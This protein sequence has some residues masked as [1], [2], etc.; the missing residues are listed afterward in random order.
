VTAA[1]GGAGLLALLVA[2]RERRL[3]GGRVEWS[4]DASWHPDE[5]G[6]MRAHDRATGKALAW[7]PL[8]GSQQAFLRC[9]VP[10]VLFEGSRGGGK[11]L[12]LLMDFGQH[13]GR[14]Y[15]A[16]WNGILF[17]RTYPELKD[18]IAKSKRL[19][20]SLFRGA[21]YNEGGHEWRW[22]GGET[23]RFAFMEREADYWKY[24]GF[25]FS[26]IAWEE[27]TTWPTDE[28]YRL[29]FSCLRS[30]NPN[31]PKRVRSTT[32]PFGRGHSWVKQRFG[33][34]SARGSV[35]SPVI[36]EDGVPERASVKSHLEENVVLLHADPSYVQR[37]R[38]AA[39]NPMQLQAWLEGSWDI[40][41]G[42][43]FDD[44]WRRDVHVLPSI[45][46]SSIPAS[47]RIFRAYDDG[48][49]RPFSVGWYARSS[50]E[51]LALG[52]RKIGEVRGDLIRFAEW[53]GWNGQ[54]NEGAR[55]S[56]REIA[57]GIVEREVAMGIRDRCR[58]GPADTAIWNGSPDDPAKSVASQ[59]EIEGVSW[60]QADKRPG[61]RRNGWKLIRDLLV[62]AIADAE[63]RREE[64]GLF[65][66]EACRHFIR[67]VPVLPRDDRD[68]DDVDTE[69][70]D[71][72]LVGETL[73]DTDAGPIRID[74]L[75]RR[76]VVWT[77]RGWQN[78]ENPRRTRI[79]TDI[80]RVRC[81]DGRE[82]V[83][84]PDHQLLTT[85]GWIEA[86]DAIGKEIIYHPIQSSSDRRSRSSSALDTTYAA[87]TT[88]EGGDG[89]IASFGKRIAERFL[90]AI[91]SIT[92]MAIARTTPSRTWNY[93]SL[94]TIFPTMDERPK[95]VSGR[96]ALSPS[97]EKP[98]ASG[99]DRRRASDGTRSTI[100]R[101]DEGST[102]SWTS[103]A[104]NAARLFAAWLAR[105]SVRTRVSRPGGEKLG[106]TT[107]RS[108]A[109][110]AELRS[111]R[112][113]TSR[114]SDAPTVVV[115]V[116]PAGRADAWC[117]SVPATSSFSVAGGLIVHNCGDELRYAC[118]APD[119]GLSAR[120]RFRV[121]SRP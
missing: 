70:E 109:P 38:A 86:K 11:T 37:L 27:L 90:A 3:S 118:A 6:A 120:E 95:R 78:F 60:E 98:R 41:A 18:V 7:A 67:T 4:D 29:M 69:A 19:F 2:E 77:E 35:V 1:A 61:S 117:V 54:P 68:P 43:M 33:L 55:M 25:G 63:G 110:R 34:P 112:I 66:S 108:D 58:P 99:T 8:P 50:G 88:S 40:V 48:Q 115:A 114:R 94:V 81:R 45:P 47:W 57:R 76:G 101:S 46:A 53:Y 121:L 82:I 42:G 92:S 15:G 96:C 89:S 97:P 12:T 103:R 83:C 65:V 30:P 111:S 49:S 93:F 51:P 119:A 59:M 106:S 22:P 107:S 100:G 9:D 20:P 104:S 24:H 72:C 28:L 14:G 5:R 75:P 39:S 44:L 36:A 84:T 23:L 56:S 21:I 80:V 13:V 62:G 31:V 105:A 10:E 91:T 52:G 32:N 74:R 102:R 71:H 87:F 73:V 116:E 26:W 113:A 17:R 85:E 79:D 16:D 64:P